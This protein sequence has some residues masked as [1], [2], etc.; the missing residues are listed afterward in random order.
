MQDSKLYTYA[1]T[2]LDFNET[3]AAVV[4]LRQ[5]LGQRERGVLTQ[6][7]LDGSFA[8]LTA[9]NPEGQSEHPRN[10]QL[11][12]ALRST[13]E[14]EAE[15]I[16]LLDGCSPDR[17]HREPSIAAAIP[18]QRALEIALQYQQ[19]AFFWFDGVS[20][21]LVGAWEPLG[22]VRLPLS[23]QPTPIPSRLDPLL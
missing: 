17:T 8:V 5:P 6:L 21:Y 3:A 18:E 16:V 14:G 11:Q 13:L 15:R 23:Q 9:Y 7:G 1:N 20:F 4:D 22:R 19:D 10:Q 2:V 12:E